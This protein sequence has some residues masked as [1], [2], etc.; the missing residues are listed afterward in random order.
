MTALDGLRLKIQLELDKKLN[1][2]LVGFGSFG[3]IYYKTINGKICANETTINT[4]T[5]TKSNYT[6]YIFKKRGF[7]RL[8]YQYDG[9]E[10]NI[11]K[12]HITGDGSNLPAHLKEIYKEGKKEKCILQKTA[13]ESEI[14]G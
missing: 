9:G 1:L 2:A 6:P 12:Q 11:F 13:E 3:K 7:R 8:V 4:E 14:S 5:D 10:G